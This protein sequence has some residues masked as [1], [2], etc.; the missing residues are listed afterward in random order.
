MSH[1][2]NILIAVD[3]SEHSQAVVNRAKQVADTDGATLHLAHIIE[4]VTG[5]YSFEV[6]ISQYD[7]FQRAHHKAVSA[8]LS[9]L[10]SVTGLSLQDNAI[11]LVE[12]RPAR[13]LRKLCEELDIDLLV[14]GSHGYGLILSA[15]GSTTSSVMH[16]ISCDVLT[17]RV[18]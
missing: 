13:Q 18:P 4:P 3:L 2:H 7:D 11:H 15:L 14:I 10:L 5:D 9:K 12:G 6:E 16:G 8:E 1:Y 17:V